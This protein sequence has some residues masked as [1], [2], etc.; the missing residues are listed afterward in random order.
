MKRLFLLTISLAA[1][2][3]THAQ[4]NGDKSPISNIFKAERLTP[5]D[6]GVIHIGAGSQSAGKATGTGGSRWYSQFQQE[7]AGGYT[8][9]GIVNDYVFPI[10]WDSTQYYHY[11]DTFAPLSWIAVGQFI[12]PV[13]STGFNQTLPGFYEGTDIKIN[14]A[15]PYTVDSIRFRAAYMIGTAGNPATVDTLFL[16]VA[17]VPYYD[18]VFT[19]ND[20]PDA[21]NYPDVK[22]HNNEIRAQLLNKVDTNRRLDY[23]GA[24][25]WMIPLDPAARQNKTS[26]GSY[27]TSDFRI[28]VPGGLNVPAG[29]GFAISVAFKPG[30]A[31]TPK[32]SV[33]KYHYFMPIGAEFAQNTR[34]PYFYYEYLDH[35]M[36][37]MM[38]SSLPVTFLSA[39]RLELRNG[40]DFGYEIVDIGGHVICNTCWD[41]GVGK[42]SAIDKFG[43]Y[44]NPATDEI[45]VS[46]TLLKTTDL[47]ITVANAVGQVLSTRKIE[48]TMNGK[49]VF[50][51]AAFAPGL[52]FYTVSADGQSITRRF[53]VVR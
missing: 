39:I 19:A 17:P 36:S 6:A 5:V 41:L 12:D 1:F 4:Q 50:E 25:K 47:N 51:T 34:M 8:S 38:H 35:T 29:Q 24:V 44:P 23:P 49:A 18:T 43:A 11:I 40:I 21:I 3:I 28:E 15:T 7:Q 46:Y 26:N 10:A 48:N 42:T 13:Y 27:P 31:Y 30:E 2:L 20:Y 52:Y 32:D 16:S 53:S 9:G 37:Y 33:Q 22:K 45:T 14:P